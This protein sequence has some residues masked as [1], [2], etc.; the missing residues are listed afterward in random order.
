MATSSG[1]LLPFLLSCYSPLPFQQPECFLKS[2]KDHSVPLPPLKPSV[3]SHRT[4]NEM[5]LC[6][7][8]QEHPRH[9][10]GGFIKHRML[11]PVPRV[12]ESGGVGGPRELAF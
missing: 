11:G 9:H 10:R 2:S 8:A 6:H 3:G 7:L 12:S 5:K 1:S 4:W